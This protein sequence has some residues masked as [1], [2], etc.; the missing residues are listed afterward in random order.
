[1]KIGNTQIN[2]KAL[3]SVI[4]EGKLLS[5]LKGKIDVPFSKIWDNVKPKESTEDD[6]V[7]QVRNST[8]KRT[9]A[10]K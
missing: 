9:K 8:P 3:S 6:K 5:Q 2:T 4:S 10:R 7:R 1:M